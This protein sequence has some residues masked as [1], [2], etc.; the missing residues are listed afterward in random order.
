M[1]GYVVVDRHTR[2]Y[3]STGNGHIT[4]Y[5]TSKAAKRR[6]SVLNNA[7]CPKIDRWV[8]SEV[9]VSQPYE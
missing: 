6:A 9:R 8:S 4:V 3:A 5:R 7:V 1:I 2:Q